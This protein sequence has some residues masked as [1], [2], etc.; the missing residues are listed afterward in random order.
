MS[1][2]Y[3]NLD[4]ERKLFETY[5]SVAYIDECGR[6]SLGGGAYV[7]VVVLQKSC[8]SV[9]PPPVN[10]S[11]KISS[12]KREQLIE[13]IKD[14]VICFGVGSASA[15]EVDLYGINASLYL[16]AQRAYDLNKVDYIVLDGKHNWLKSDLYKVFDATINNITT[17]VETV[18]KGDATSV[19]LACA[20]ILCKVQHDYDVVELMKENPEYLW[21][22]HKGYPTKKHKSLVKEFGYT[23]HHRKTWK[24]N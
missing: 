7:G 11:K 17:P 22:T 1:A 9:Q 18:I 15:T 21:D 6:G 16:A 12:N 14:W 10:D 2:S 13:G 3:P 8:L 24:L 4:L 19:G 20:S 23:K 5:T